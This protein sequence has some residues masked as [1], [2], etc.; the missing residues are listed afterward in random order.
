MNTADFV[1]AAVG[2]TA[3]VLDRMQ[4]LVD[5]N[6][7]VIVIDTAHGHSMGVIETV[8]KIKKA[9]PEVQLIAGNVASRSY[10]GSY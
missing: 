3:D 4:A 5:A 9:F 6:V 1:G 10:K 2:A 8:K 7:D